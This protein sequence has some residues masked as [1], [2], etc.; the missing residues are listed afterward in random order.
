VQGLLANLPMAVILAAGV[1]GPLAGWLA[2]RRSRNPVIWFIYGVVTGPI[3]LG[4]LVAAPPGRCPSCDLPVEGWPRVCAGCGV[5][6]G[7]LP[8]RPRPRIV[9]SLPSGADLPA[10]GPTVGAGPFG[11][12]GPSAP[13]PIT[14]LR[15]TLVERTWPTNP[16]QPMITPSNRAFVDHGSANAEVLATG[17]Y[18]SGNAG[19]EI[20]ACYAVARVGDRLRIFGPVDTGQLTVRHER[21]IAD[22]EVVAVDDRMIIEMRRGRSST[23][24]VLRSIG[25]MPPID[26]ERTI[27]AGPDLA[28][29][30][31]AAG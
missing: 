18:M 19:L 7:M 20:G 17:V 8:A 31:G 5:R 30:H 25:G 13:P 27:M 21:D 2:M 28:D 22:V 14:V 15:P 16:P 10:A 24:M 4:L 23:A 9:H 3:A 11:Q 6:L 12:R 29:P 26:L 1:G